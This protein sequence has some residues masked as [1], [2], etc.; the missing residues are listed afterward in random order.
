MLPTR[1]APP[2]GATVHHEQIVAVN[3]FAGHPLPVSRCTPARTPSDHREAPEP[4]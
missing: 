2:A 3:R 1:P 4:S